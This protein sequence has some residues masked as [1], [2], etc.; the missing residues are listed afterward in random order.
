MLVLVLLALSY[1]VHRTLTL[2]W[3]TDFG[4]TDFSCECASGSLLPISF[5]SPDEI[6]LVEDI[7]AANTVQML[8]LALASGIKHVRCGV[9]GVGLPV[10]KNMA[11][12]LANFQFQELR[13]PRAKSIYHM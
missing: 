5:D 7:T 3:Q 10:A 11:L 8:L 13:P 4:F 12:A 6:T 2:H 9:W 1:T